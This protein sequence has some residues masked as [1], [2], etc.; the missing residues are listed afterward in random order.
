MKVTQIVKNAIEARVKEMAEPKRKVIQEQLDKLYEEQGN[1][2]ADIKL[3]VKNSFIASF[4]QALS[5]IIKNHP[6]ITLCKKTYYGSNVSLITPS[7]IAEN[8]SEDISYSYIKYKQDEEDKLMTQIS[9]LNDKVSKNVSDIIL[10]LELGGNK[11]T[12]DNLLKKVKF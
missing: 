7:E 1:H 4:E 9:E 8:L 5:N 12:L 6:E 3:A 11:A 10:E 2:L